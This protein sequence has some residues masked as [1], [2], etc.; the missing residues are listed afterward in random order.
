MASS[1]ILIFFALYVVVVAIV[2]LL[3]KFS[4]KNMG[5]TIRSLKGRMADISRENEN[6]TRMVLKHKNDFG[7][8]LE[9]ISARVESLS[10]KAKQEKVSVKAK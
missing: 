10:K 9:E 4:N 7:S 2:I 1:E 6:L 5:E 3:I 8:K